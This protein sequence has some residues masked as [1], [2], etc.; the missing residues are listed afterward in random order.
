MGPLDLSRLESDIIACRRCSRL[1]RY[2][3][4]VAEEKVARHAGESYWGRPVP[5]FGLP[6]ARMWILGLAPAAHGGNRTGR[7]FTGDRS[8][9]FLFQSLYEAGFC[10]QPTSISASDGLK[11]YDLFISAVVR[12]APP[13]N[14]PTKEEF[15]ACQPFLEREFLALDSLR[16]VLAL[17]HVA[18]RQYQSMTASLFPELSIRVPPFSHGRLI[19]APSPHHPAILCAYH[20]SARNTQTGLLTFSMMQEVLL[21]AKSYLK[22][23]TRFDPLEGKVRV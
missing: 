2:R 19:D 7:V 5:G 12:C 22:G 21:Q 18:Y 13:D 6:D 23:N 14:R 4:K 15:S 11:V 17:G 20:P 16:L 8:G 1:V 3:E 9:D 10:N